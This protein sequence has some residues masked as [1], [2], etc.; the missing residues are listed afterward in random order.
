[1]VKFTVATA[2]YNRARTLIRVYGSLKDQT[3]RDFEW[4]IVDDGSTDK[5]LS[6]VN[7]FK[8]E[9]DFPIKYIYKE[10]GGKHSAINLAVS[11]AQGEFFVIVDSDDSFKPESLEILNNYWEKIPENEREQ[12]RGVSCRCYDPL[13]GKII[14]RKIPDRASKIIGI[15]ARF[16]YKLLFDMWGFNRTE[17]ME[18]F[19][20]PDTTNENLAFYPEN[21]IWDKMDETYKVY[22]INES[23][24][25]YYRD[26]N[27]DSTKKYGRSKENYYL[28]KHYINDMM[29]HFGY[30]PFLFLKSY[31]GL[32]MDGI[33]QGKGLREIVKDVNSPVSKLVTILLSPVGFILSHAR[34]W[35]R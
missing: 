20:F 23:L 19:P 2:T 10:N 3:F 31:V 28:W 21:I 35:K 34:R 24:L 27:T 29:G 32:T 22:F 13:T 1:M 17:I 5:T 6:V 9:A 7:E 12:Y 18:K 16:E 8:K 4:I 15:K 14:G 26:E 33:S 11:H 30:A 25:A